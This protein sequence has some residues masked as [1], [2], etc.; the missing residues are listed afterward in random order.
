MKEIISD[1]NL[2]DLCRYHHKDEPLYTRVD[3][4][5]KV[6]TRIDHIYCTKKILELSTPSFIN[7]WNSSDHLLLSFKLKLLNKKII[8]KNK[9]WVF[10]KYVLNQEITHLINL[11]LIDLNNIV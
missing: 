11:Q 8:I 7:E 1:F 5:K 2:I 10:D 9:K 6:R 4:G 3:K